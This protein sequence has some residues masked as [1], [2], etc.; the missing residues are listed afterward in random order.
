[1]GQNIVAWRDEGGKVCV[2]N[3]TCPHLG[4][5][6]SPQFG[7]ILDQGE[8]VCP[9]HGLRYNTDGVCVRLQNELPKSR[10]ELRVFPVLEINNLIFAYWH[11]QSKT[12]DWRIPELPQ[13]GWSPYL[14]DSK[15]I[16]VHPQETAENAPDY[17]H[18]SQVHGYSNVKGVEKPTLEGPLFQNGFTMSRRVHF[19]LL[20][21]D[22]DLDISVTIW[23]LGYFL[24]ETRSDY[25]GV[26]GRQLTL[27][28]PIDE[29]H[30]NYVM[31]F[32]V[33]HVQ[34]PNRLY[35]GFQLL[36]RRLVRYILGHISFRI[37]NN[38]IAQDIRIWENKKYLP[39]PRLTHVD[40]P[41]LQFRRWC[42]Q[43][44]ANSKNSVS[45]GKIPVKD[46][47][48]SISSNQI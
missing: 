40:G 28:T 16:R 35:P 20:T 41:V 11:P 27:N 24:V 6:L 4:A 10:I 3:A 1:M 46:D 5:N 39:H 30:T 44:Y 23:G 47:S 45:E 22:Y 17:Q 32:Q 21:R 25:L 37:F 9:F 42:E 29:E 14:V 36:P 33:S 15:T 19:G 26:T 7:G 18:L 8:L 13:Q 12:P 48:E 34:H 2:A 43:F 31:V 38:D